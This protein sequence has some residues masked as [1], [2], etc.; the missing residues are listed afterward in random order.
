MCLRR[1]CEEQCTADRMDLDIVQRVEL[2]SEKVVKDDGGLLGWCCWVY[3]GD[4][5]REM[6]AS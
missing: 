2:P 1:I 4:R 3:R 5:R 6:S